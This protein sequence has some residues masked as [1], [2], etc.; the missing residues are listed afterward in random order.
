MA[1]ENET[2]RYKQLDGGLTEQLMEHEPP[3][4]AEPI[5]TDVEEDAPLNPVLKR[6]IT[7]L[8]C[9]GLCDAIEYSIV[10]PSLSK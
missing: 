6:S 9:V 2:R 1:A 5:V 8:S 10:M 3:A 7:V 4:K